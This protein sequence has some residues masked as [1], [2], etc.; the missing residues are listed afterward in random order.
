MKKDASWGR[1][2]EVLLEMTYFFLSLFQRGTWNDG[3]FSAAGDRFMG[4]SLDQKIIYPSRKS[5]TGKRFYSPGDGSDPVQ[6]AMVR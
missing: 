1:W 6:L 2:G 5:S 3:R 4:V